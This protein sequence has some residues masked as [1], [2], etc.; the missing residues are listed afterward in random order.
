MKHISTNDGK[1]VYLQTMNWF[2]CFVLHNTISLE[3]S[4]GSQVKD[5]AWWLVLG[6]FT[7]TELYA[8]KRISFSDQITTRMELPNASINLQVNGLC[9]LSFFPPFLFVSRP[10]QAVT[11]YYDWRCQNNLVVGLDMFIIHIYHTQHI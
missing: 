3:V 11:P 4:F 7:S 2:A 9:N 6:N 5:E 1:I 8:L 10:I